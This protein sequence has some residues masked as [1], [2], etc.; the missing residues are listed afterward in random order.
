MPSTP[1]EA[2][3]TGDGVHLD[4]QANG[5]TVTGAAA[6]NAALAAFGTRLWPIDLATAPDDVRS[7]LRQPELTA[8]ES[9]LVRDTFLL[10][11][12]RLL[13]I[14]AASGRTPTVPEGGEL[15]TLD[16]AN[17]VVYPQLYIVEPGVD[18][19][20]FDRLHENA[21]DDGTNVDEVMLILSGGSIR[22]VQRLPDATEATLHLSCISNDMGWL[23]SYGGHPHIGSF[24]CAEPGTKVLVQAIGPARWRAHY[25]TS[26]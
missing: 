11:R 3:P 5:C 6:A 26:Q 21:A 4:L 24:T 15:S 22:L 2:A 20:R 9:A 23:V 8:A 7:R 1:P 25:I 18:Y 19:S 16:V 10:S 13:E 14:I 12:A 17:D